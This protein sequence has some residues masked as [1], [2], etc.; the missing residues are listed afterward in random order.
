LGSLQ[1]CLLRGTKYSLVDAT[2]ELA[3][4]PLSQECKSKGKAAIDGVGSRLGKSGGALVYQVLLMCFGSIMGSTPIVA[5]LLLLAIFAWIFSA[6]ALGKK[7]HQ[8]TAEQQ[9][10]NIPDEEKAPEPTP[11][12]TTS[13]S[14][15]R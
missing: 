3:F 6:K 1:N 2:K 4:V 13:S 15:L 7:F 5:G 10:L 9:V 11:L 14:V 8:L 12:E